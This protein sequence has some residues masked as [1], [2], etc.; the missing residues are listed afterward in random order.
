M[1]EWI[2]FDPPVQLVFVSFSKWMVEAIDFCVS[3]FTINSTTLS[4]FESCPPHPY[5]EDL[6]HQNAAEESI[7]YLFTYVLCIYVCSMK[8]CEYTHTC[9][10]MWK[11]RVDVCYSSLSLSTLYFEMG[12]HKEHGSYYFRQQILETT[13]S[14]CMD[15][16]C[17]AIFL[18]SMSAKEIWTHALM[19]T[20]QTLN[21]LNWMEP[22]SVRMQGPR[23]TERRW[24]EG[25]GES[26]HLE[27]R[28]KISEKP[29]L[30]AP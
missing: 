1:V 15:C 17:H 20:Q 5:V 14:P 25:P 10:C 22:I 21:S 28:R 27:P 16:R 6:T 3:L 2:Q 26:S 30:P 12:F 7:F 23:P 18:F 19:P 8:T 24:H 13:W 9:I 4:R 29:A 11:P